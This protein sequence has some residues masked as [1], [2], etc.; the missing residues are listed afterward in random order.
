MMF[1]E[2]RDSYRFFMDFGFL[3]FWRSLQRLVEKSGLVLDVT[4][5]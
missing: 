2:I 4:L 3:K 5:W 1:P